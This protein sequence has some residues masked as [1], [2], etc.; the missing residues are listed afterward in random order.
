MLAEIVFATALTVLF[1]TL[2][3]EAFDIDFGQMMKNLKEKYGQQW[4]D[5]IEFTYNYTLI[6]GG[7]LLISSLVT[8]IFIVPMM[9]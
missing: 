6:F 5:L 9:Y 3:A 4:G 8:G 1:L 2:G 7:S